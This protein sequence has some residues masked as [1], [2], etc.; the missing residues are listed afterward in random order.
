MEQ[1]TL[2]LR[3][4]VKLKKSKLYRNRGQ[5]RRSY[6]LHATDPNTGETFGA[7]ISQHAAE[8]LEKFG[9]EVVDAEPGLKVVPAE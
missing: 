2:D 8:L 7:S 1:V 5:M 9:M 6:S 3:H 4:D